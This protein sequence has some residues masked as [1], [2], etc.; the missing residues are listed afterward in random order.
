MDVANIDKNTDMESLSKKLTDN[1][2]S[3]LTG[4]YKLKFGI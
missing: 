3:R 2:M 4:A 1:I